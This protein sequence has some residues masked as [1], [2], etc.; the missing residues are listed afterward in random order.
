VAR[1]QEE[2]AEGYQ[3]T[4]RSPRI[5]EGPSGRLTGK[6]AYLAALARVFPEPFLAAAALRG[7]FGLAG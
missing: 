3:R 4:S 2:N 5:D 6:V 7:A 1:R